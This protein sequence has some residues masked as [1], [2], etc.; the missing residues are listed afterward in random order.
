[1]LLHQCTGPATVLCRRQCLRAMSTGWWFQ[2]RK[3]LVVWRG[4]CRDEGQ[5]NYQRIQGRLTLRWV[6][7]THLYVPV[8]MTITTV[9]DVVTRNEHN[10]IMNVLCINV[11]CEKNVW[12]CLPDAS[13]W[14]LER[15]RQNS[16]R[17]TSSDFCQIWP[18]GRPTG[19]YHVVRCETIHP[20]ITENVQVI[21]SML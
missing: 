19:Q 15:R 8:N 10:T 11:V 6:A 4:R 17:W 1:M 18:A 16:W 14:V 21:I 13:D 5:V 20:G 12:S 3:W 2:K 9:E 7:C